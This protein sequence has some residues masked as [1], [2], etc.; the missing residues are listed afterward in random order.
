MVKGQ[1]GPILLDELIGANF[2]ILSRQLLPEPCFGGQ[3]AEDWRRRGGRVA[4]IGS[5]SAT[6]SEPSGCAP[7]VVREQGRL[8]ADWMDSL[9]AEAVIVR[10]DRHVYGV[11][12]SAGQVAAMTH[13]LIDELDRD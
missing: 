12:S 2:A 8:F 7:I 4:V 11:A 6:V 9:Q 13:S 3:L 5:A 10:P 1:L